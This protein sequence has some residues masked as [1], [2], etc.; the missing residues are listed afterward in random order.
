MKQ[1]NVS[2]LS[3]FDLYKSIVIFYHNRVNTYLSSQW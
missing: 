1:M 2:H 3:D